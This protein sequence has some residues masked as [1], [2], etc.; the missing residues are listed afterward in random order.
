MPV[1]TQACAPL[2]WARVPS[3]GSL[4]WVTQPQ[5]KSTSRRTAQA[6]TI[7]TVPFAGIAK[8]H[9]PSELEGLMLAPKAGKPTGTA[10]LAD[11]HKVQGEILHADEFSF[12][13]REPAGNVRTFDTLTG[14]R[15]VADDPLRAHRELLPKYT[16]KDIHDVF[17][18]LETLR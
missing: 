6:A 1:S 14:N 5:A 9:D 10:T 2:R 17:A 16:N 12:S 18:Y 7:Q 11:G 15:L 3:V 4:R 8:R 13:L